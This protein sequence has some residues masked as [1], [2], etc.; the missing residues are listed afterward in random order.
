MMKITCG[1][2]VGEQGKNKKKADR[3][4]LE[5]IY[6]IFVNVVKIYVISPLPNTFCH[7]FVNRDSLFVQE[8][9]EDILG[10]VHSRDVHCGHY[11]Q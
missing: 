5:L 8:V 9:R 1:N 10:E 4:Q 11:L 7:L 3:S 6:P 2:E